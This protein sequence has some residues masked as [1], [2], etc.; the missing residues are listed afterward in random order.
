MLLAFLKGFI[1]LTWSE[2]GKEIV[3]ALIKLLSRSLTHIPIKCH[4]LRPQFHQLNPTISFLDLSINFIKSHTTYHVSL[5]ACFCQKIIW[6]FQ[7]HV[8]YVV[9]MSH[10]LRDFQVSIPTEQY[11]S[12]ILTISTW[13]MQVLSPIFHFGSSFNKTCNVHMLHQVIQVITK[14]SL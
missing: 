9:D 3:L 10:N 5:E 1:F 12:C 2:E 4:W 11:M 13:F 6:Q 8:K 14:F 7:Q